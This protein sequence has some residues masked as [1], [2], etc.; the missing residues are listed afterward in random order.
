MKNVELEKVSGDDARDP[1][2]DNLKVVRTPSGPAYQSLNQS[3]EYFANQFSNGFYGTRFK[4]E[5]RDYKE[6]AHALALEL[7]GKE[8]FAALLENEDYAE[9]AGRAGKLINATNLVYKNEKM[10]LH[11]GLAEPLAQ[12]EFSHALYALLYSDDE[13][14]G[15]FEAFARVLDDIGAA[16]W[17]I[18][19]YF[20]F[21]V[22]P[23]NHMFVKPT[24]TQ[25]AAQLCGYEINYRP[26][27][28]WLTYKSVLGLAGYLF[29][30]LAELKP[31]DM[32]D[33]G[34]F[35][36]CIAPGTYDSE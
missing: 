23:D 1:L 31:R 2:L 9:I 6:R 35:M 30:Q 15:R 32:I 3:K 34:S 28:N 17:T 11:D 24:V 4:E 29:D 36:W 27:L 21:L 18:A 8:Q 20:L 13:L 22:W 10:A 14:K 26:E 12:R 25:H 5:E 33:V 16:K 19:T 7:V